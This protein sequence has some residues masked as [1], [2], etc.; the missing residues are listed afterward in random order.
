MP[1]LCLI[2]PRSSLTACWSFLWISE[3]AHPTGVKGPQSGFQLRFPGDECG[4]SFHV[5]LGHR[6][7]FFREI[8][9]RALCPYFGGFVFCLATQF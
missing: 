9:R 4:T 3:S 1:I 2:S 7:I 6:Y 5:L 8:F